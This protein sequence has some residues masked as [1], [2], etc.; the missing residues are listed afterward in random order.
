MYGKKRIVIQ[1]NGQIVL[2]GSDGNGGNWC[3]VGW[4]RVDVGLDGTRRASVLKDIYVRDD[5]QT[6][7]APS[8]KALRAAI[9]DKYQWITKGG[10]R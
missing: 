8:K 6:I 2:A 7:S 4:L 3:P 5:F 10:A 1:K 9:N